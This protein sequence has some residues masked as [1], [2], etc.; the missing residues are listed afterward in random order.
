[1]AFIH[2]LDPIGFNNCKSLVEDTRYPLKTVHTHLMN[3]LDSRTFKEIEVRKELKQMF[4]KDLNSLE[5]ANGR[6]EFRFF[7][8]KYSLVGVNCQLKQFYGD[9]AELEKLEV[10]RCFTSYLKKREDD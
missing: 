3:A 6:Q 5:T 4:A 2:L 10:D 9:S 7:V 8:V 1:M